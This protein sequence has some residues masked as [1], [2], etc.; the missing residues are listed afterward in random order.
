MIAR[1]QQSNIKPIVASR[2]AN[3]GG[4][5][6]RVVPRPLPPRHPRPAPR[7]PHPLTQTSSIVPTLAHELNQRQG[8]RDTVPLMSKFH[9]SG[10][11]SPEKK[12]SAN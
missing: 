7:P 11:D 1:Y 9:K 10:P 12:E 8:S 3:L 6:I 2:G 4:F 5:F